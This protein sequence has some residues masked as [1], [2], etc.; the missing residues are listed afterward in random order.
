MFTGSLRAF[1]ETVRLGSIRKASEALGVAPSSVSRHVA[2]LEREMG[3]TLFDRRARG[4]ELTHAGRLVADYARAV[5]S[6]YDALRTDLDDVR[7]SQRRLVRLAVVESVAHYGPIGAISNFL[8]QHPTVTFSVRVM[9]APRVIEAVRQ[10]QCDAGVT[11]CAAPT[12]DIAVLESL[13]EPIVL[14]IRADHAIA[15]QPELD[16][17]DLKG[18]PLALPDSDFG[19]RQVV[20][21]AAAAAGFQIHPVLSSNVFDT[22]RDFARLG[23]GGAVLPLRAALAR[24]SEEVL[25]II[26]LTGKPFTDARIDIVVGNRRL[27]RLIRTFVTRLID[28]IG[29]LDGR[30]DQPNAIRL[31]RP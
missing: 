4:V 17:Q 24:E 30:D 20:D 27:P 14:A 29:R 16:I 8:N 31:P 1:D 22:L 7:G 19:V 6:E 10:G 2:L 18:L 13:P 3:T 23:A 15:E 11:F 9:P 21:Q 12:P 25:A 26:P 5:L 28:E